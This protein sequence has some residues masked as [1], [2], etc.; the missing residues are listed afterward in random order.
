MRSSWGG[1]LKV[2]SDRHYL[3]QSA[4]D[5]AGVRFIRASRWL[6]T[7]QNEEPRAALAK[8]VDRYLAA[9]GPATRTGLLRWWGVSE[10]RV[11]QSIL[12]AF[13]DAV[14]GV[15]VGGVRAWARRQDLDAIASTKPTSGDVHLVG[16]FDPFIVGAG[17]REQL[18]PSAHLK[19]VSRT[20]GWISP[21]VLVDGVAA[22]VWDPKA[23]AKGIAIKVDLFEPAPAGRRASIATAAE[24]VGTA[25]GLP[26]TVEYGPVFDAPPNGKSFNDR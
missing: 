19:R 1:G 6:G 7:W 21:V 22:G 25:L 17:L 9:Y 4:E 13:G 3:V 5:D 2:A 18:I 23:S 11:M 15:E 26:V 12:E 14:V 24:R 16:G 8:L 10:T 20:A